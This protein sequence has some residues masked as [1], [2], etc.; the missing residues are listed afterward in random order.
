M[1]NRSKLADLDDEISKLETT[2]KEKI[3]QIDSISD[4]ERRWNAL[5]KRI[6]SIVK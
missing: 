3:E 2:I 6:S 4:E 1:T 5:I